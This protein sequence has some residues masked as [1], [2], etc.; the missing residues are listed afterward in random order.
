[1][2]TILNLA[3]SPVFYSWGREDNS[4]QPHF[5]L[6]H[7]PEFSICSSYIRKIPG[8]VDVPPRS[9]PTL[10]QSLQQDPLGT[11]VLLSFFLFFCR[12]TLLWFKSDYTNCVAVGNVF[13]RTGNVAE[14]CQRSWLC[15][16]CF[17][18]CPRATALLCSVPT[19]LLKLNSD[20]QLVHWRT[21]FT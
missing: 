12:H 6:L 16:F 19:I 9:S 4:F 17:T 3:K 15:V 14:P 5:W 21:V 18:S 8:W 7:Y 1:M 13:T 11:V 20:Q 2:H 10:L